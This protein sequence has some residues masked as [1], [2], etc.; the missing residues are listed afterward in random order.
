ME[1]VAGNES[2]SIRKSSN[3][4]KSHVDASQYAIV[5]THG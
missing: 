1:G 5:L 2:P 3:I 4:N